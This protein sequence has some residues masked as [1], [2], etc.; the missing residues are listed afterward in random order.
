VPST[1]DVF[2][3]YYKLEEKKR[4]TYMK[5]QTIGDVNQALRHEPEF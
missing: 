4:C 3:L 1:H 2:V 5:A